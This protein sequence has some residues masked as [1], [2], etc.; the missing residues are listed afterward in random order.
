M[1]PDQSRQTSR[2]GV[3]ELRR[4]RQHYNAATRTPVR[5]L[6]PPERLGLSRLVTRYTLDNMRADDEV[7]THVFILV[8]SGSLVSRAWASSTK[9]SLSSRFLKSSYTFCFKKKT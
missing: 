7:P 6:G 3:R 4:I 9:S 8:M 2:D 5:G 1:E